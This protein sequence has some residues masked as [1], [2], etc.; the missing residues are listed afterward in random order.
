MSLDAAMVPSRGRTSPT[1]SDVDPLPLTESAT[2]GRQRSDCGTELLLGL[3]AALTQVL[4]GVL[5]RR[6]LAKPSRSWAS[7]SRSVALAVI[8]SMR[9]SWAG[10]TRRNRHFTQA[11]SCTHGVP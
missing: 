2:R 9:G 7:A 1:P 5:Q 6:H 4:Q 10:S 3:G 8:S 11:C